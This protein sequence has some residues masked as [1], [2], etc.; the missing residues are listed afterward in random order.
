[1]AD[2]ERSKHQRQYS[3][4]T[5]LGRASLGLAAAV[6]FGAISGKLFLAPFLKKR[7]SPNFPK[8]SIF[9]PRNEPP[10]RI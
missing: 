1:M 7:F 4:R 3:R 6:A 9:T 5:F 8:D 2:L 10:T